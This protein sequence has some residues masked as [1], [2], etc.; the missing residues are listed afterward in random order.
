[1]KLMHKIKEKE[2]GKQ[3]STEIQYK[4]KLQQSGAEWCSKSL[5]KMLSRPSAVASRQIKLKANTHRKRRCSPLLLPLLPLLLQLLCQLGHASVLTSGG[6]NEAGGTAGQAFSQ[7]LTT[8]TGVARSDDNSFRPILP[9]DVSPE[10][11]SRNVFTK[12]G[13][14]RVFQPVE[15]ESDLRLAVAMKRRD[16]MREDAPAGAHNVQAEARSKPTQMSTTATTTIART[17]TT[18]T[19]TTPTTTTKPFERVKQ[20]NESSTVMQNELQGLEDLLT[21]YVQQFFNEGKYEAMP[22]LVFALQKNHTTQHVEKPARLERSIFESANVELN[23]P[24]AL[25]SARLL[26]FAGKTL[27]KQYSRT[28]T[29]ESRSPTG[30]KK[31]MW[32]IYMALQ[33]LKSLLF[34]LFLPTIIGSVSRLIGKGE[35]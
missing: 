14:Y 28:R 31:I 7:P 34:A 4:N 8:M 23:V 12:S 19:T 20:L 9:R 10:F 24:R 5:M 25:Q 35:Y 18:T 26:F 33:V 3:N 30:L 17:T 27:R 2:K 1:M 16:Y 11:I 15:G 6:H 13:Q 32:P 21:E 29:N 22:G